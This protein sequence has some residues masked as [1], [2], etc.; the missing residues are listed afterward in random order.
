VEALRHA[1]TAQDWA[2]AI[3]V[4]AA[5][6]HDLVL[7]GDAEAPR[8]TVPAP[9]AGVVDAEPEVALAYA[10]DRLDRVDLPGTETYLRLADRHRHLLEGDRKDRFTLMTAAFRLAE[11]QLTGDVVSVQSFAPKMLAGVDTVVP[12]EAPGD[13]SA[14]SIALTALGSARLGICDIDAAEDALSSGLAAADRAGLAAQTSFCAGQLA[15]ARA[16]RG[17][18]QLA[19][20]TAQAGLATVPPPDQGQPVRSS[21]PLLAI[22]SVCYQRDQLADAEHH[23]GLAGHS[24]D[25]RS[26][27][28]LIVATAIL[29]SLLL[30]ARGDLAHAY[31]VLLDARRGL[32]NRTPSSYLEHWLAA[33]ETD[34]RTLHGDTDA[35]RGLVTPLLDEVH[36]VSA[37][38]TLALARA[39]IH[40]GNASA[41]VHALDN[42]TDDRRAE[43]I[44]WLQ[45]DG[46]LLEAL[47]LHGVG[48]V[49]DAHRRLEDVLG[50]A[51]PEGCR[52]IFVQGGSALRRLLV[53]H[54]DSG[55]AHW[56]MLT[57]FAEAT[58]DEGAATAEP[59][60]TPGGA[61]TERELVV[62]RYLQSALSNDE[63]AAELYLSVHTVKTHVRNIYRKLGVGRRRDAVRTARELGLL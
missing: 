19:L 33:T 56:S 61:F 38:L 41:A 16:L 50:L 20:D 29:R 12:G 57:E 13:E 25:A 49:Q 37:P 24:W 10:A 2:C 32:G 4:L 51:E 18:L 14:R 11:A 47:A 7:R 39:Y 54:L 40:D 58:L 30:Q 22:A 6:W 27:P 5:H 35:A 55:T 43:R 3:G 9:P 52:R 62:L 21:Y 15:V 59:G 28:F 26:E 36:G 31:Q 8:R 46:G 17:E 23:L 34:L 44:L 53:E 63:I 60:P 1:L 45:L 42:W 48:D